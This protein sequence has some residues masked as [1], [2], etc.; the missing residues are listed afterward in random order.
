MWFENYHL[1]YLMWSPLDKHNPLLV[2]IKKKT[3]LLR[4]KNE[5]KMKMNQTVS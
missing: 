4:L 1:T 2:T 5:K 3:Q